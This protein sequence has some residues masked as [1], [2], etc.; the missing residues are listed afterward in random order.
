MIAIIIMTFVIF[1]LSLKKVDTS[2]IMATV[3]IFLITSIRIIPSINRILT[4]L[5]H[6]KYAEASFDSL[7]IDLDPAKKF[8]VIDKINQS[9]NKINFQK[10]I[11][12]NDVFFL[13]NVLNYISRNIFC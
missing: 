4:S 12:F 10:E 13:G 5:Q 11:K 8:P 7:L 6:I 1:F 3:G 2:A 9:D